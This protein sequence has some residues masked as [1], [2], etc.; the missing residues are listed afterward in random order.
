MLDLIVIGAGPAGM[1]AA[2]EAAA[3]GLDVLVLDEQGAP[4][5]QIYRAIEAQE[6]PRHGQPDVLG[7]DYWRGR[8]AVDRFRASGSGYVPGATVWTVEPDPPT[9]GYVTEA[10]G[11]VV[12]QARRIVVATGAYER[13]V[14]IP[15]W[16][17]PGVMTAGAAQTLM[18]SSG[19]V[20]DD[21]VILA[22]SGPL[23]MLVGEQLLASGVEVG[24]FVETTAWDD[25][26]SA[27][28]HLPSALLAPRLL[29]K[30][31][32]MRRRIKASGVPM[33]SGARGL[34]AEGEGRFRRLC[35]ETRGRPHRLDGDLLLLHEGVVPNVQIS[36]ALRLEHTWHPAQR[37]W[38]PACDTW[39]VT[40]AEA[41]LVAGDGGGID[42]AQAAEVGGRLAGLRIAHD[43][44]RL[45]VLERD[46]L[47][48]PLFARRSSEMRIRP[49]L[50]HLYRPSQAVICPADPETIVCRCE[51]VDVASVLAATSAGASGPNQL[52][53]FTRCGMGPCQGRLC[54]LT[55]AELMARQLGRPV[56]E[57]GSYRIRP[58]IKPV[59]IA[60]LASVGNG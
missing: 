51:D 2:T 45:T 54:G 57:I 23:L 55:V 19:A 14:P 39:G 44:D 3:H 15:G 25:Y 8:E 16:T 47:A 56:E 29:A 6:R 24:G 28:R 34:R 31:L 5:G 18:K 48:A 53:A 7:A 21:R 32:A 12:R 42:G 1:G 20:F 4:G 17:L 43:L 30:G 38:R 46:R 35:F 22:G 36:R 33:Y 50:D 49:L 13:P 52:K 58:P 59:T 40:S 37:Y 41:I 11:A 9:V 60:M 27:L 10:G 26:R